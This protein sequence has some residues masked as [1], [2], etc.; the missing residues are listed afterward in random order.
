[1]SLQLIL[2]FIQNNLFFILM[3]LPTI[4]VE[5]VPT[6]RHWR[7]GVYIKKKKKNR[8][9][10]LRGMINGYQAFQ[11][12]FRSMYFYKIFKLLFFLSINYRCPFFFFL[13]LFIYYYYFSC[14]RDRFYRVTLI[15]T[16]FDK[17]GKKEEQTSFNQL[18]CDTEYTK[19]TEPCAV[20]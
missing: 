20:V 18:T 6:R 2:V 3:L 17:E 1:M 12:D 15:M 10:D 9:T 16:R 11:N 13:L 4:P 8:P 14:R 5:Y 7:C 19:G